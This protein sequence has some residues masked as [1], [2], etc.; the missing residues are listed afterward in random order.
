VDKGN[1]SAK[2]ILRIHKGGGDLTLQMKQWRSN[3]KAFKN[4]ADLVAEID[5]SLPPN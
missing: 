4:T 1:F 2:N 3:L 5:Q